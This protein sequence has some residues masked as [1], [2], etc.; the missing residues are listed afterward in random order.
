MPAQKRSQRSW[1]IYLTFLVAVGP[2]ST[3][4]YLPALPALPAMTMAL[5]ASVTEVQTTLSIFMIGFAGSQLI[6][7]P[8]SDRFGRKPIIISGLL[9]Y[10]AASVVC[11]MA[12][13]IQILIAGRFVQALGACAGPVL[14]RAIVRDLYEPED[15]LRILAAMGTA[16]A[17]APALAPIIG[18]WLLQVFGWRSG[19]AA[20]VV[21]GVLLSAT[22]LFTLSETN[23]F[24]G[25]TPLNPLGIL[26]NFSLLLKNR[27]F[28]GYSG[29]MA[30]TFGGLFC[31]VSG[32]SFVVIDV[33]HVA[34]ANFGYAFACMVAGLASGSAVVG[35]LSRIYRA[36][37][38]IGIGIAITLTA[39]LLMTVLAWCGVETLWAVLAPTAVFALGTGIMM[40]TCMASSIGPFPR[41]AGSASSL[42][43]F[44]Q[45]VLGA[46]S[47]WIVG[48]LHDGTTR[49][50]A[51]TML[52]FAVVAALIYVTQIRRTY[53]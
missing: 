20:M 7:G 16:M 1:L 32:S 15:S 19:F 2:L 13:N 44:A 21:F 11:W 35:R 10:L 39:T 40:P 28:R 29:V 12:P 24:R 46:S 26:K 52:S 18:G 36:A 22:T 14:G 48:A 42:A 27:A 5:S 38:I 8:L 31:F 34:P 45:G 9:L 33:L 47:G 17:M 6:A 25:Q 41:L 50:L 30:L 49:G 53:A 51:T 4:L 43:G 37:E 23:A 3:D